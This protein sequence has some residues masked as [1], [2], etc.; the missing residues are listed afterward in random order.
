MREVCSQCCVISGE[1]G[2][3][4]T[5]S[6]KYLIQHLAKITANEESRRLC[7]KIKQVGGASGMVTVNEESRRLCSKI[8]QVGAW[9]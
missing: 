7:S 1:S 9:C 2:S 4:K 5:E 6:C 3:G 8:K